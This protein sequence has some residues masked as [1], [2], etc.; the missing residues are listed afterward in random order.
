LRN[1]QTETPEDMMKV[2]KPWSQ[3]SGRSIS[4]VERAGSRTQ[5]GRGI[6]FRPYV[7]I[8]QGISKT[9]ERDIAF[10]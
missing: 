4:K 2:R 7:N 1:L 6:E 5:P 9:K 3:V 10:G 8:N